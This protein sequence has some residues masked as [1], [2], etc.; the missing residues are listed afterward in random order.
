MNEFTRYAKQLAWPAAA[1][2]SILAAGAPAAAGEAGIGHAIHTWGASAHRSPD[3]ARKNE[4]WIQRLARDLTASPG[5][6]IVLAGGSLP[7]NICWAA[8][9]A[10]SM[11]TTVKPRKTP[12]SRSPAMR[13]A[14]TGGDDAPARK[15]VARHIIRP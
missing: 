7:Q 13:T 4:I 12:L 5:T 3:A 9:V 6:Q 1:L 8:I 14:A 11:E 2:V 10:A 15:D